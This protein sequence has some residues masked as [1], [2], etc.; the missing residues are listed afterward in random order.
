MT[1]L[2]TYSSDLNSLFDILSEESQTTINW[3]KANHMIVNPKEI[4]AILISKRKNTIP[5]DLTI[6]RHR[7]KQFS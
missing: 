6:N 3:L 2:S 4:Q 7:A 1:T 5:E